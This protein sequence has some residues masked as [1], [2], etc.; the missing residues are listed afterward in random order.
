VW[1]LSIRTVVCV[2]LLA[3][4][5]LSC[6]YNIQH[7]CAKQ[8]VGFGLSSDFATSFIATV[9]SLTERLREK[10]FRTFSEFIART[11]YFLRED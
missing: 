6:D 3:A 1:Q 7:F 10:Y 11:L 9:F 8:S 4:L 2:R 5:V